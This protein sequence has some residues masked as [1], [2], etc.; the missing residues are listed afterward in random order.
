MLKCNN[1]LCLKF[2][3][4]NY[5]I[6]HRC[7]LAEFYLQISRQKMQKNIYADGKTIYVFDDKNN[8]KKE[9]EILGNTTCVS[10]KDTTILFSA[11][12]KGFYLFDI[13][14]HEKPILYST[15]LKDIM[16]ISFYKDKSIIYC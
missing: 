5:C 9:I 12:E 14:I 2:F 4:S 15:K 1:S 7:G 10:Q 3:E 13:D 16:T 11:S 8:T 6:N